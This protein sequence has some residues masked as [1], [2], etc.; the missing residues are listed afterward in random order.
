MASVKI[1]W[2]IKKVGFLSHDSFI[3][4]FQFKLA[5]YPKFGPNAYLHRRVK[6]GTSNLNETNSVGTGGCYSHTWH[7][8]R[9]Q[10]T[11]EWHWT[12]IFWMHLLWNAKRMKRDLTLPLLCSWCSRHTH[13]TLFQAWPQSS[14]RV[15]ATWVT[16][17]RD[18]GYPK[19]R[20]TCHQTK[21]PEIL[22][23][24]SS[25]SGGDL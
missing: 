11:L 23:V 22:R 25:V 20:S 24:D 3:F 13:T 4:K 19:H 16:H 14:L 18:L 8:L 21:H 9:S 1:L 7:V 6:D 10:T 17:W 5:V 15:P 12:W 2:A